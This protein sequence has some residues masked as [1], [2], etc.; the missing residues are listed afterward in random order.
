M[1]RTGAHGPANRLMGIDSRA[2]KLAGLPSYMHHHSCGLLPGDSTLRLWAFYLTTAKWFDPFI[3]FCILVNSVCMAFADPLAPG[4]DYHTDSAANA[5]LFAAEILFTTIFTI[6]II[7]KVHL[8]MAP[9]ADGL[10][11]WRCLCAW[12]AKQCLLAGLLLARSRGVRWLRVWL[13]G[14]LSGK[15]SY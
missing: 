9:A 2:L 14:R 13:S 7:L 15:G 12:L 3:V 1:G 11:I 6:E 4:C 5:F 10:F 8:L